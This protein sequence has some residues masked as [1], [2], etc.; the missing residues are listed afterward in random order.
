M[1]QRVESVEWSVEGKMFDALLNLE[2][3]CV[4]IYKV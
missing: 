1:K 2:K 3:R 4:I